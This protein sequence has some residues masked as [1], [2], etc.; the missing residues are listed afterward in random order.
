MTSAEEVQHIPCSI[1]ARQAKQPAPE[2]Q[3]VHVF[4]ASTCNFDWPYFG[5]QARRG[6]HMWRDQ[7]MAS[8][9]EV[10]HITSSIGA[11]V[12]KS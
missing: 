1:G 12:N 3:L 10:P 11:C 9:E 6:A 5:P 8:T 7:S 4:F 2:E